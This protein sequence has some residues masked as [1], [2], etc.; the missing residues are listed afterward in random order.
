MKKALTLL[1][2]IAT[3][4]FSV[5]AQSKS[6]TQTTTTSSTEKPRSY[7][8]LSTGINNIAG[9]A[10]LTFEA[11]F[12]ENASG[13]LG[14][15]IGSWGVKIG[16]AAK[17][18]KQYASSWSFGAGYSTASGAGAVELQLSRAATPK[19]NEAVK[20]DLNRAHMVDLVAGKAW[21]KSVKFSLELGYSV[22]VGGATYAT[23]DKNFVLS[24]DS[25]AVLN[26][27]RPG[28][29]IVGMGLLFRL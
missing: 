14:L 6:K 24:D 26:V 12:S 18:Y 21:G 28:G 25:K 10:G 29:L 17:Y 22:R 27:I 13:K 23:V 20:V 3:T 7:L 15:G 4:T 1:A 9:F 19:T 16:L 8:G 2:L 5:F 11:P